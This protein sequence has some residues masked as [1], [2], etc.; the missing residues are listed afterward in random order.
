MVVVPQGALLVLLA[1]S[2]QGW[3]ADLARIGKHA[4]WVWDHD[5]FWTFF[6]LLFGF[7]VLSGLFTVGVG[8]S[9]LLANLVIGLFYSVSCKSC[10]VSW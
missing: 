6:H 2:C 4:R 9:P 10:G 7:S 3:L 8:L 1:T 5:C